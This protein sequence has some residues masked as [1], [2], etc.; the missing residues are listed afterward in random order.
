M[1]SVQTFALTGAQA[2]ISKRTAGRAVIFA[3][4]F[5]FYFATVLSSWAK[6]DAPAL[7][8]AFFVFS[9]FAL[10]FAVMSA[11]FLVNRRLPRARNFSFLLSRSMLHVIAV[12]TFFKAVEVTSVA[13]GNILNMTYPLFSALFVWL[14]LKQQQDAF[15]ALMAVVAFCG[16]A[17]VLSPG[18]WH[19]AWQSAWGLISAVSSGAAIIFLN[20]TRQQNDTPTILFWVFG[21]GALILA[22]VFHAQFFVPNRLELLY[23]FASA[24]L[25][26]IGQYLMTLGFRY[27]T[28]VEGGIIS[29]VRILL[30]ALLG[31]LLTT[32]A[33]LTAGGWGGALLIL[34]ANIYFILRK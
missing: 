2:F 16:I 27:V 8:S 3:S 7:T 34:T 23:L 18:E 24:A 20:L 12:F 1:E 19:L 15:A 13:E 33:G 9:R 17:L 10:G 5:C 21:S 32:E 25:G 29:S 22:L 11:L 28:A 31:P 14:F 30:A 6:T 4:E 26:V